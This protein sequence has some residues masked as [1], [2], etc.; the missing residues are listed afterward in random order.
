MSDELVVGEFNDSYKP[1][2][3]G[4][5]VCAENYAKWINRAV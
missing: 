1:I 5:G 3:D 2:M 4:V